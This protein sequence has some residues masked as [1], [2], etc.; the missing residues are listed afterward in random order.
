VG[1]RRPTSDEMRWFPRTRQAHYP[2]RFTA[3]SPQTRGDI[4]QSGAFVGFVHLGI[5]AVGIHLAFYP[6]EVEG[7]EPSVPLDTLA[8]KA[9]AIVH[10]AILPKRLDEEREGRSPELPV[11]HPVHIA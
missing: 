4:G 9:S 2:V 11:F 1:F 10:S 5:S 8:F 6:T 3:G 7:F